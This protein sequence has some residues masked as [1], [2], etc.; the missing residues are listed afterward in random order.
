[1][2]RKYIFIILACMLSFKLAICQTDSIQVKYKLDKFFLPN[3]DTI[4]SLQLIAL[5]DNTPIPRASDMPRNARWNGY[6]QNVDIE[7]FNIA[8]KVIYK[9]SSIYALHVKG[10]D[11]PRAGIWVKANLTS[12]AKIE[13]SP[14]AGTDDIRYYNNSMNTVSNPIPLTVPGYND[15]LIKISDFVASLDSNSIRIKLLKHYIYKTFSG[16][17]SSGN[18]LSTTP[19]GARL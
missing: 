14:L 8:T 7:L 1:M 2:N 10:R 16:D 12:T 18:K 4:A 6:I 5:H 17:P 11:M 3:G 13:I 9:D 15:F 19:A